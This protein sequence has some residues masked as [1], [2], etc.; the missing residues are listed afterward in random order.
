LVQ[1]TVAN[2]PGNARD[3]VGLYLS[4]GSD[5]ALLDWKYLNGTRAVPASGVTSATVAFALPATPGTYNFRFFQNNTYAKLATSPTVT[6]QAGPS[7]TLTANPTTVAGGGT[8]QVTVAGGP[9]NAT[10]WIGLYRVGAVDTGFTDW[11]YLNGTRTPP[12]TGLTGAA[13]SFVMP[14][15]PG[16]F[17]FRLFRSN[18]YTRLATSQTVAVP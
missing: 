17:E 4:S 16:T 9:G 11:K 8:V 18:G 7:P 14:Q 15:F 10:D 6:V 13:V 3:W 5:T 1:V 12:A 2:G